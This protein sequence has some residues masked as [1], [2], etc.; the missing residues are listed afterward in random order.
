M[1]EK[2]LDISSKATDLQTFGDNDTFKLLC[3][4]VS[5]EEGWSK[6]TRVCNLPAGCVVQ[7][8]TLQENMDRRTYSVAEAIT[9]VPGVNIDLNANPRK[10]VA[11]TSAA[12]SGTQTTGL[13][14]EAN[15]ASISN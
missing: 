4:S 5:K 15:T 14:A 8:S 6:S 9:Y 11:I 12:A 3:K 1:R 2:S 13:T 7:V 10:L